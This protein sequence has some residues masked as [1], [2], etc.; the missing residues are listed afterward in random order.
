MRD[1]LVCV[2]HWGVGY[3]FF[4][5]LGRW[6]RCRCHGPPCPHEVGIYQASEKTPTEEDGMS[7]SV[8]VAVAG[9]ERR[10]P[11]GF[12]AYCSASAL[13][14]Q[15][16]DGGGVGLVDE[17]GAGVDRQATTKGVLVGDVEVQRE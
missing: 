9:A 5:Y 17:T 6:Y 10:P 13:C 14:N 11:P 4:F 16:L 1:P 12:I 15:I 8:G 2:H 7:T 3:I